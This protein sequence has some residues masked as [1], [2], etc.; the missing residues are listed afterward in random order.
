MI[1]DL[2]QVGDSLTGTA[3]ME[4]DGMPTD[5]QADLIGT[6]HDGKLDLH[7]RYEGLRMTGTLRRDVIRARVVPGRY[8]EASAFEATFT[9]VQ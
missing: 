9:R 1:L 2:V 4:K 8:K 3:L 5:T 7:A 6:I